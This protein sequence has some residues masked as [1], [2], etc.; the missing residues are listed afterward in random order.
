MHPGIALLAAA[1]VGSAAVDVTLR[2]SPESMER[3]KAVA[4]RLELAAAESRAEMERMAREGALVKVAGGTHYEVA[5]WVNPYAVP[6]VRLFV[7][8][9]SRQ[10]REACGEALMVTSLTRPLDEQPPNAHALSVHPAGMAAD[11]RIPKNP[12]CREWIEMAF[13]NLE[14]QGVIDATRERSPPHYHVAI[15]PQSYARFAAARIAQEQPEG[16][17]AAGAG[18]ALPGEEGALGDDDADAEG[19]AGAPLL[20]TLL[21]IIAAAAVIAAVAWWAARRARGRNAEV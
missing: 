3:Q 13:L 2:G 19:A 17:T 15:F 4:E 18:G 7:E 12:A 14:R 9:L 10:Y 16:T 6:E 5:D 1:L 20:T 21:G 8:R 11:F